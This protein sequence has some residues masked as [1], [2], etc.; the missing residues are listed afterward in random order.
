MSD[1][2]NIFTITKA[3]LMQ[4]VDS[5]AYPSNTIIQGYQPPTT[6]NFIVMLRPNFEKTSITSVDSYQYTTEGDVY[7]KI[8]QLLYKNLMQI[9]FYSDDTQANAYTAPDNAATFHNYLCSNAQEYLGDNYLGNEI[10]VIEEVRNLTELLDKPGYTLRYSQR[11]ELFTH[12]Y[13]DINV[14]YFTAVD[15]TNRFTDTIP[16]IAPLPG[17]E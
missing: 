12:N 4:C 13:Y 5:A 3:L 17:A 11:F 7:T 14:D 10:G 2:Q 9:D 15:V 8:S 6:G 16:A 1:I